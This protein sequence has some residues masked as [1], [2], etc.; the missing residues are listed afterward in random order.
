MS[1]VTGTRI[2]L[3]SKCVCIDCICSYLSFPSSQLPLVIHHPAISQWSLQGG[4]ILWGQCLWSQLASVRQSCLTALACM[5]GVYFELWSSPEPF[6][7]LLL[8]LVGITVHVLVFTWCWRSSS[9]STRRQAWCCVL[10]VPWAAAGPALSGSQP[11]SAFSRTS[12]AARGLCRGQLSKLHCRLRS[13][14]GLSSLCCDKIPSCSGFLLP[15]AFLFHPIIPF[16]CSPL[17]SCPFHSFFSIS[18]FGLLF[19]LHI[20]GKSRQQPG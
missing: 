11:H 5:S 9:A 13:C 8:H 6:N 17:F 4:K 15:P 19:L 7:G 1:A 18:P 20:E 3:A 10:L 16:P 12:S 2:H 14:N